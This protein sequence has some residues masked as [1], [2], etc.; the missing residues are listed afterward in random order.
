M[1][2][3]S[4]IQCYGFLLLQ[5][6]GLPRKPWKGNGPSHKQLQIFISILVTGQAS[7]GLSLNRC[8]G[9]IFNSQANTVVTQWKHT[10]LLRPKK[11]EPGTQLDHSLT[12]ARGSGFRSSRNTV[13]KVL[14]PFIKDNRLGTGMVYEKPAFHPN[15]SP[16]SHAEHRNQVGTSHNTREGQSL[17]SVSLFTQGPGS[18]CLSWLSITVIKQEDQPGL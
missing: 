3:L 12:N 4:L 14:V 8:L 11:K 6:V 2:A 15:V 9:S 13:Y 5:E 10:E 17:C 7:I 16:R 18:L 1:P